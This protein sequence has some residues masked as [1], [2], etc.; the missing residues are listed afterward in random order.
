MLALAASYALEEVPPS[1][2]APNDDRAPSAPATIQPEAPG[3]REGKA[4]VVV[5]P[6][7]DQIAPPVLYVIRRGLKDAIDSGADLVVLDMETPGGRLDTTFEILEALDRF[8]GATATFINKEAISAGAFISAVT[9]DIYF[10]PTGV[11]GAAAPVMSTGGEIDESMK[12]KI[13]SYLRARVRAIS[14]GHA[15]RGEVISAM[16]DADYVLEIEGEVLKPAGELLSLTASEA[17]QTYGTP[18]QPLLSDGIAESVEELLDLR[19]GVEGYEMTTLVTTWSEDLAA[20]LNGISPLLLGLGFL[21]LFIE[22]KTPGF[23]VFGILG[24][25]LVMIVFFGKY[26]AGL[27][28]HEPALFFFLGVVLVLLE[29]LFFPGIFVAALSG[30]VLMLGSLVWAMADFWPNEP[31]SFSGDVLFQPVMNVGMALIIA[32]VGGIAV[33]R[34]MPSGWIWDR[35][36]LATSVGDGSK[37]ANAEKAASEEALIGEVGEATTDLFPSGQVSIGGR[38]YEAKVAVGTVEKGTRVR[39]SGRDGFSLLVQP[40]EEDEA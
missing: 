4:Q 26:T 33:V 18:P 17:A 24:G 12:Q 8:P 28:G 21:G 3:E 11:I 19:F 1:R 22:F 13:V 5:I 15:Y 9:D 29:V 38:W 6:V 2:S 31:I 25:I 35:L 27:S 39:V 30:V 10:A 23:G 7:R 37:A 16:I 36:V 20:F 40:I 14:E 34:F 32:V